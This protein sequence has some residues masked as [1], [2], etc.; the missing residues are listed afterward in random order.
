ME[1]VEFTIAAVYRIAVIS[2]GYGGHSLCAFTMNLGMLWQKERGCV[3]SALLGTEISR[4]KELFSGHSSCMR[5]MRPKG[6]GF[7]VAS[8]FCVF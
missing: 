7:F 8:V 2:A 5:G 1:G 6:S 3:R 4:S